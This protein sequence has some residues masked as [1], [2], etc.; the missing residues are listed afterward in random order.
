MDKKLYV[1]PGSKGKI[2]SVNATPRLYRCK[3]C[4]NTFVFL[5][6][7]LIYPEIVIQKTDRYKYEVVEICYRQE[8]DINERVERC[9]ICNSTDVEFVEIS[10]EMVKN[11]RIK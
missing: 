5:G 9:G 10:D 7:A 2:G 4:E 11:D 3:N 8:K 1:F 6:K